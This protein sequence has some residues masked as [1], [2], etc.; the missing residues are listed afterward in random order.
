MTVSEYVS[1]ATVA[2]Q[3]CQQPIPLPARRPAQDGKIKLRSPVDSQSTPTPATWPV[4]GG[5]GGF[6]ILDGA[7]R[8][9]VSAGTRRDIRRVKTNRMMQGISWLVFVMLAAALYVIRFR[10]GL[11]GVPPETLRLAGLIAIGMAYLLMIAL[12]LKDN[13]FDGLLAIVV[14]FYPFYYLFFVSSALFLRALVAALLVGFG[15]D[16]ALF[17]QDG[18]VGVFN[19][20]NNWIRHV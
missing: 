5:A 19:G 12:A 1:G 20:V 8:R 18:W 10:C 11:P 3:A 16:L 6:D 15:Y 4:A 9:K 17:L 13:M 7:Q 14:P 2:C